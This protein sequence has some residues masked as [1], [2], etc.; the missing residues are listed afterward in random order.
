MKYI[1]NK[2]KLLYEKDY[3]PFIILAIGMLIFH[4]AVN[5]NFGD[6][7][8]FKKVLN[9]ENLIEWLRVRYMTWSSRTVIEGV[10]VIIL[11]CSI[12][13]W[14][15]LDSAIVVLLAVS[16]S[17]VCIKSGS[18]SI[19]WI[20][21]SLIFLYPFRDMSSAG[22]GATT[23]NYLWPLSFG[24]YSF[25]IVKK[26]YNNYNIKG[27]EYVLSTLALMF[28]A[29]QEQ[30]CAILFSLYCALTLYF[31][32]K[33]KNKRYI[34]LQTCICLV[35]L[36]WILKCPGNI[37][38]KVNEV[39]QWFP[40]YNTLLFINKTDIG[41]SSSM[42]QFICNPNSVFIIFS[43]LA[44]ILTIIKCR[45]NMF[46]I[47]SG[48]PLG[49]GL[50]FSIF[51]NNIALFFPELLKI[52]N[53]S[54]QYGTITTDN[55][56]SLKSYIPIFLYGMTGICVLLALYFCFGNNVKTILTMLIILLG[57]ASRIIMGF[58]PTIWA[59]GNRT[60]LFMYFAFII[61]TIMIYEEILKSN[62][63]KLNFI[64]C[65]IGIASILSFINIMYT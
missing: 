29:N 22:W 50:F 16:L 46:R 36:I 56:Y 43:I 9:D 15:I 39:G 17:K 8:S 49:V 3:F 20:I 30:M 5:V 35:N 23:L 18:R 53:Y 57:L 59:S 41:F 51:R 27:Y 10:M 60:F 63:N 44:F 25:I 33:R 2:I 14:R 45:D 19:N 64:N 6:D 48:I 40:D 37:V 34:I 65:G 47:I 38:R 52:L 21:V 12:F 61:C 26:I 55:F 28:A 54:S 11:G 31:F 1:E 42:V 62:F 7:L 24:I 32:I 4:L 58:S 13:L